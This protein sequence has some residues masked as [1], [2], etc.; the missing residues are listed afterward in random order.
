MQES[1]FPMTPAPLPTVSRET[2]HPH[3]ITE[4]TSE[5]LDRLDEVAI[6]LRQSICFLVNPDM[7]L[8]GMKDYSSC[9]MGRKL[10]FG[11]KRISTRSP[12]RSP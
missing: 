7:A 11:R 6:D 10:R 2:A 4:Q 3:Q 1:D 9:D 12:L 5:E 8:H